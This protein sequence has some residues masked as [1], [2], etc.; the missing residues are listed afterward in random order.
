MRIS[1][2][3][4]TTLRTV[5][6]VLEDKLTPDEVDELEH[7]ADEADAYLDMQEQYDGTAKYSDDELEEMARRIAAGTTF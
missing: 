1:R 3:H 2:E 4:I 6:N 7:I 5:I